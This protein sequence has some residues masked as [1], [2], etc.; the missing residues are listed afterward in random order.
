[1]NRTDMLMPSQPV[2]P[3]PKAKQQYPAI[4]AQEF[5]LAHDRY[6]IIDDDIYHIGA[7]L[8]YLGKRWFAISKMEMRAIEMMGRVGI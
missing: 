1:M 8:K 6:L 3:S 5:K 2:I 7:S 4:E